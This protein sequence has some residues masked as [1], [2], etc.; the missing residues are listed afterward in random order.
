MKKRNLFKLIVA[1]VVSQLAGAVGSF[2]T[3]PA[4]S[5]GWYA[6]LGKPA[7]N[8]PSWVFAPAWTALFLLMGI[9]VWLVWMKMDSRDDKRIKIALWIFGGQLVL[10]ALWSVIFFGLK[11]PG[12]A[13]VEII[14]LWLAILAT[15][16]AFAKISKIAAWLL[17]P[18]I[19]WVGFAGYLNFSIWQLS[20]NKDIPEEK[21]VAELLVECLPMSD[22]AS[23]ERC[24][25]LLAGITGFDSCVSAGFDI[26]KS[27]PPQCAVPDGRIFME[28]KLQITDITIGTGAEAKAGN[29]VTVNYSGTLLDGKKFDSSYDRGV[30]FSFH[31][32]A[33][34]VIKGWDLGVAGMKAGGK[35]KLVIPP[36]L[37]YGSAEIG[38]GLIPANSTL[39]FE[40]ELLD[41]K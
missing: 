8:P 22:W 3:T 17:V 15:T 30:P 11:S 4:I 27:N 5:S 41:A 21:T 36:D 37:A 12:W 28:N 10:N 2:F 1:I 13:F 9:A 19:L 35:R 24:D 40:V 31:L 16:I 29:T 34:E 14:I 26:M 32:G 33:G 39:V 7:L 38:N 18:Y 25:A 6:T 20:L 23:K